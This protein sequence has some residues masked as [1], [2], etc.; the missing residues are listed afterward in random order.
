MFLAYLLACGDPACPETGIEPGEVVVVFDDS[1]TG[2]EGADAWASSAG[3]D[4]VAILGA[5]T[6]LV[7]VPVG[8]ECEVASDLVGGGPPI[9]DAYV[10][11]VVH[12]EP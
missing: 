9:V 10:N 1:V 7:A 11:F 12:T 4:V 6:I 2:A 8:D 5:S 3:Y